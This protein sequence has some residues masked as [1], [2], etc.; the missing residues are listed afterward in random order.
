[1]LCYFVEHCC[2]IVGLL[3]LSFLCSI[4]DS[5]ESLT[6]AYSNEVQ[7]IG[8]VWFEPAICCQRQAAPP[9][10][11]FHQSRVQIA[12]WEQLPGSGLQPNKP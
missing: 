3:P 11:R 6:Q 12:A 7:L 8:P 4:T 10:C 9:G 2:E 1:M 5:L